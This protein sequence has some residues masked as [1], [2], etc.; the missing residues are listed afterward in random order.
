MDTNKQNFE[1]LIT[2][3]GSTDSDAKRNAA[4]QLGELGDRRAVEPLIHMLD[5]DNPDMI[6]VAA[7]ALG[8]LGDERAIIPLI[9]HLDNQWVVHGLENLGKNALL[10]IINA[11]RTTQGQKRKNA[12]Q[13]IRQFHFLHHSWA[14]PVIEAQA[15]EPILQMLQDEDEENRGYA[16][17]VLG[18]IGKAEAV[19]AIVGLAKAPS[20]YVRW[21]VA[22]VLGILGDVTTIPVLECMRQND[23]G[24]IDVYLDADE[25]YTEKISD[26]AAKSIAKI[27]A[28]I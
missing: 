4:Y 25:Q 12:L 7:S 15:F 20:D 2:N 10:A 22:Q 6:Y 21:C 23:T 13:G 17:V 3:L 19:S 26:V 28:R 16:V 8:T 5:D 24:T 18:D 1:S 14:R 11:L 27:Q 9:D